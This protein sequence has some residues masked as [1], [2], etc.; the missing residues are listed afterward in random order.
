MQRT[1]EDH[2][3]ERSFAVFQRLFSSAGRA[4][5][6]VCGSAIR[7][8]GEEADQE[9]ERPRPHGANCG[10]KEEVREEEVTESA[11]ARSY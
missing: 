7:A 11:R 5:G 6:G 1:S 10:E 4:I 2:C 8:A 3:A 9:D